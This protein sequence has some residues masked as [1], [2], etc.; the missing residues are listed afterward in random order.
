MQSLL[1]SDSQLNLLP[2]ALGLEKHTDCRETEVPSADR[3]WNKEDTT[4]SE[5]LAGL[6]QGNL[7]ELTP[8]RHCQRVL[9]SGPWHVQR[10]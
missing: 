1:H 2:A 5:S 7:L 10:P 6:P 9:S 4:W 8:K 3:T